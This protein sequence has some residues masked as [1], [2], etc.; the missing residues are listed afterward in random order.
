[1]VCITLCTDLRKFRSYMGTSVRDL[2]RAMRNKV[3]SKMWYI[4]AM[5]CVFHIETSLSRAAG[6]A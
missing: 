4:C 2:L 5:V 3:T 6:A 1:M